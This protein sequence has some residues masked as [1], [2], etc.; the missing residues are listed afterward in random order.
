M[1]IYCQILKLLEIQNCMVLN[2]KES[3]YINIFLILKVLTVVIA[4][5]MLDFG[6]ILLKI[7]LLIFSFLPLLLLPSF[8]SILFLW[9]TLLNSKVDPG[10]SWFS[11]KEEFSLDL[12]SFNTRDAD[13][14]I[15]F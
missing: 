14:Q 6:L 1:S 10:L 3:F 15:R 5:T 13:P 8:L 4:E 12:F 11:I 2:S 9:V 7:E